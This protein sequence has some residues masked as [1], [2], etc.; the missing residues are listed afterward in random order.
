MLKQ[1]T[2]ALTLKRPD[3]ILFDTDNMPNKNK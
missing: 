3:A 1:L 2:P